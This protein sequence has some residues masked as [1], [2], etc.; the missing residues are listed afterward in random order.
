MEYDRLFGLFSHQKPAIIILLINLSIQNSH[1]TNNN[2]NKSLIT[3]TSNLFN[4]TP[5]ILKILLNQD[6]FW[7][8]NYN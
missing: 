1:G 3:F 6:N 4:E 7:N 5:C 2:S 8:M